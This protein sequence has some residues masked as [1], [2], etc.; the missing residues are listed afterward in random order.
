MN[1]TQ[2]LKDFSIDIPLPNDWNHFIYKS[3][4]DFN[5]LFGHKVGKQYEFTCSHCKTTHIVS[6]VHKMGS[7]YKCPS[8]KLN[9]KYLNDKI[10]KSQHG[11]E[12]ISRFDKVNGNVV[13]RTFVIYTGIHSALDCKQK[14]YEIQRDIITSQELSNIALAKKTKITKGMFGVEGG[15]W[16][17]RVS[18]AKNWHFNDLSGKWEYDEVLEQWRYPSSN[19]NFDFYT[20]LYPPK[21]FFKG[22]PFEYSQLNKLATSKEKIKFDVLDYLTV[23]YH[24][25]KLELLIKSGFGYLIPDIMQENAYGTR[26]LIEDA[27][28]K[29]LIK[30]LSI[31][32]TKFLRSKP[33]L[34]AIKVFKVVKDLKIAITI[35]KNEGYILHSY[36]EIMRY[37]PIKKA[38]AYLQN[39]GKIRDA[40]M[41]KDY[42]KAAKN[43]GMN[44]TDKEVLYPLNLK[45]AHDE[46]FEK[47]KQIHSDIISKGIIKASDT[48][49]MYAFQHGDLEIRPIHDIDELVNESKELSHCV[50][51][52]DERIANGETGIFVVRKIKEHERP[53]V[54]VELKGKELIQARAKQNKKPPGEVDIF[55]SQWLKKKVVVNHDS[56]NLIRA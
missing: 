4:R 2:F 8:C 25:P 44:M 33:S 52:Y 16:G 47:E 36:E 56:T 3:S 43:I 51:S 35:A 14:V 13:F 12:F 39:K 20:I 45:Q 1:K 7:Y 34:K 50:R 21:D 48:L 30:I 9:L 6:N 53:F 28:A 29:A 24:Q 32:K 23:Y 46:A 10:A 49:M 27:E 18:K 37:V 41:Y 40:S 17:H 42:L 19:C 15:N 22:T 11:R 31:N 38:I 5:F 26:T 55:L 54:T